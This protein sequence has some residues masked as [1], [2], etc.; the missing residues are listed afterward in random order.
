MR[1]DVH[2][3]TN[4]RRRASIYKKMRTMEVL[5]TVVTV[6]FDIYGVNEYVGA[7]RSR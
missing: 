2:R 6:R 3:G 5:R 1:G 4:L 7:V